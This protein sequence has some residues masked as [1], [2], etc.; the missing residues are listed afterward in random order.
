MYTVF[1]Q[2]LGQSKFTV[3][4]C[5]EQVRSMN[6]ETHWKCLSMHSYPVDVDRAQYQKRKG[7]KIHFFHYYL[8]RECHSF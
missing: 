8:F 5:V 7:L 6:G 2:R 1:S 3:K 4:L